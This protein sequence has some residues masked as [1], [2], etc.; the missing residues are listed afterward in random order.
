MASI[1]RPKLLHLLAV[2]LVAVILAAPS[3][4]SADDVAP[5]TCPNINLAPVSTSDMPVVRAAILCLLNERRAQQGAAPLREEPVLRVVARLY[6]QRMADQDFFSHT[7]PEG[8]TLTARTRPYRHAA[9]DWLLGANILGSRDLRR[10]DDR[11]NLDAVAAAP[12][13]HP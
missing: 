9:S 4:A 12:P 10:G 8:G 6:A 11:A 3:A 13:E 2:L 5:T 7:D 1:R